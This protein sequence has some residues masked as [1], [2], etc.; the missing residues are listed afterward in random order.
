MVAI[1]LASKLGENLIMN[2]SFDLWQRGT[3]F[4]GIASA[5]YSADRWVY[6]KNGTMVQDS[7]RSTDVPA[8]VNGY[9]LQTQV[10]TAQ[11]SLAVG[12]FVIY[13]QHIEG[14]N[15]RQ[16]KGKNF[17][18][19]FRVKSPKTGVHCVSF[20]NNVNDRSYIAEYTVNQ[21]DTW[22]EKIIRVK[23]DSTGTWEVENLAG[24]KVSFC[25]GAGSTFQTTPGSWQS[26]NFLATANQ[27]NTLDTIG[28]TFKIAQVQIHEGIDAI[29]FE[30][31]ARDFGTELELCQR[32]YEKTYALN[33][34]PGTSD[35]NGAQMA[36]ANAS[37]HV[38]RSDFWKV[39]KRIAPV[40]NIYSPFSGA[41]N[42]LYRSTGGDVAVSSYNQTNEAGT[43]WEVLSAVSTGTRNRYHWVA[44]AEL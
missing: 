38:W 10:T 25:Q 39:R 42:N 28:N 40:F 35:F 33:V 7:S 17:V 9:S 12:D 11:P 37:S 30:K 13:A 1:N 5:Q 29:P 2:P 27:V 18:L 8:D 22:E 3:S 41:I 23:H 44:D 20:R 24:M 31:L 43:S 14:Y 16:I 32:Y 6:F 4:V 19:K 36:P 34:A 26:G 21:V 15:F